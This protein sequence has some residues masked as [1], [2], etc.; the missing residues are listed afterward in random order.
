MVQPTFSS[1]SHSH[2]LSLTAGI[3]NVLMKFIVERLV[4]R[5]NYAN[6]LTLHLKL[7]MRPNMFCLR[8]FLF[9]FNFLL[10]HPLSL[11]CLA[12]IAMPANSVIVKSLCMFSLQ[13][14]IF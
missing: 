1:T 14:C 3:S 8:L 7:N 9:L 13:V 10:T 5:L 11:N 6:E 4:E 2:R 12:I